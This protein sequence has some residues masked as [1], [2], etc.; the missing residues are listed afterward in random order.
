MNKKDLLK[1]LKLGEILLE[2]IK[3]MTSLLLD[4]NNIDEIKEVFHITDYKKYLNRVFSFVNKRNDYDLTDNYN[5]RYDKIIDYD[6]FISIIEN[7]EK[8]DDITNMLKTYVILSNYYKNYSWVNFC[9]NG[10]YQG[11]FNIF[12]TNCENSSNCIKCIDC[13]NCTDCINCIDCNT[14]YKCNNINAQN[15]R[16]LLKK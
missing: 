15:N 12:C 9:C 14:C 1:Y 11:S 16:Y 10:A 3:F 5:E 6:T 4:F 8:C 13:K 2:P 7:P